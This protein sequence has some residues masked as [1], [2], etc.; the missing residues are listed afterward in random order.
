MIPLSVLEREIVPDL[1]QRVPFDEGIRAWVAGCAT[2]EEAYSLAILLHEAITEARRPLHLKVFATDVHQAS[3]ERAALGSYRRRS[4]GGGHRGPVASLLPEERGTA[5]RFPRNLRQLIVFAR[6][7]VIKDAPFTNL[8]LI[9]CRN[10]LIYFQPQ[11][12]KKALSLFHFG[13]KTGG[14]LMLG[15]SESPGQLADE[16]DTL[17]EHSRLYRKRRDIR[18]PAD[19]RLPLSHGTFRGQGLAR[20]QA[21]IRAADGTLVRLHDKL[22][23]QFMPPSLLI[24]ERAR[25]DREL[26]RC[27][28]VAACAEATP[29]PGRARSAADRYEDFDCGCPESRHAAQTTLVIRGRAG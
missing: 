27:G 15:S 28:A 25:V 24:N 4:I 3:L 20:S 2:G 26:R 1:L 23:D 17:D 16:F 29:L 10:L 9:S 5:T 19:L 11:A 14:T 21:V 6:H 7:N 8:D 12:Q 22:L 13:L 18:L